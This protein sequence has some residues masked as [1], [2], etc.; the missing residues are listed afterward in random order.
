MNEQFIRETLIKDLINLGYPE[1]SLRQEV[2]ISFGDKF[3]GYI[4]LAVIDQNS[5]EIIAIF[6][7]KRGG[8]RIHSAVNQIILYAK[9]LPKN[10]LCYA[11][12][13]DGDKTEIAQ[14]NERD[15]FITPIDELPSYEALKSS[16]YAINKIKKKAE[17][18]LK[19]S[20]NARKWSSIV[21]GTTSA[22]TI[23]IAV[24]M[25]VGLFFS[26]SKT[27]NQTELT[28]KVLTLE[29]HSS[30]QQI[31]L[32]SI[33]LS[34]ANVNS[35]IKSLSSIPENHGWKVE[36]TELSVGLNSI[37]LRLK[38]L[39]DALTVNPA[40]ALSVP[41]LRK[42]LDNTEKSLR[43]ELLQTRAEID[44]MYD[45]NKWFIGLMFTIALSVLGM[46][47]SSFFNRN[48]T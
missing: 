20:N 5:D 47:A 46:A 30:K 43:A 42:D 9:A 12:V 16:Y 40:K 38:A 34:L 33:S 39:E 37:Q 8:S 19:K 48:D 28:N 11:Y 15:G 44:R 2:P 31:E 23:G 22:I 45:Q 1:G 6:E 32:E 3:N 27:L 26:E 35:G 17:S 36:A 41:I 18:I 14:V 21:A 29:E 10:T 25:M 24:S 4:D 7:I 13:S